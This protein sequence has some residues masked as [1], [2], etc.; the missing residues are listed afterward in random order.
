VT[1]SSV[2]LAANGTSAVTA[3]V[4]TS[5]TVAA[6]LTHSPSVFFAGIGLLGILCLLPI[7]Q[8]RKRFVHILPM[9]LLLIALGTAMVIGGMV[10]CGGGGGSSSTPSAGGTTVNKVA[11]GSYV[12]ILTATSGNT[13]RTVNLNLTVQ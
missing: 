4:L 8:L 7:A 6:H 11:P 13:V 12:L 9:Q 2:N 1:P 10:A 5:Q 3:N